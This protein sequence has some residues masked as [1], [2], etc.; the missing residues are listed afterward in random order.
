M[1]RMY[2]TGIQLPDLKAFAVSGS[3]TRNEKIIEL[4]RTAKA[5]L[6]LNDDKEHKFIP[7][8]LGDKFPG[9]AA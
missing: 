1:G 6:K 7:T 8:Q 5:V 3:V 2:F 9:L 4:W